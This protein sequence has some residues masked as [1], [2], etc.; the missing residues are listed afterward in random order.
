MKGGLLYIDL[1]QVIGFLW[2]LQ[3]LLPIK[4]YCCDIAEIMLI[5]VKTK[6][7]LSQT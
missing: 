2:V 5:I 7:H 6:I 3:F 4:T 1:R